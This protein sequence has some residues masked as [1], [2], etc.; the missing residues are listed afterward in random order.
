MRLLYSKYV[1]R[2]KTL[3]LYINQFTQNTYHL[4]RQLLAFSALAVRIDQVVLD[5]TTD[6]YCV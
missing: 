3:A 4:G 1:A 5:L 6:F 2:A